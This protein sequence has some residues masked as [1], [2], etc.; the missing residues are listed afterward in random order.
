MI[1]CQAC[2][3]QCITGWHQ[4]TMQVD[5]QALGAVPRRQRDPG[6]AV[7][8]VN[9]LIDVEYLLEQFTTPHQ[10]GLQVPAVAIKLSYIGRQAVHQTFPCNTGYASVNNSQQMHSL[11]LLCNSYEAAFALTMHC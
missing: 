9:R 7:R 6:R 11:R 3:S 4:I 5:E 2:S 8:R 1:L 10:V